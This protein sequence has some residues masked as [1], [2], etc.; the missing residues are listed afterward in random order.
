MIDLATLQDGFDV[1]ALDPQQDGSCPCFSTTINGTK[2]EGH[3]WRV[4]SRCEYVGL[5]YEGDIEIAK[6]IKPLLD[7]MNWYGEWPIVQGL[8]THENTR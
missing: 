1:L 3:C 8:R 2:I 6:A 5:H 7:K 4:C